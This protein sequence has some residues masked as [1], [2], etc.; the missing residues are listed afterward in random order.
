[1]KKISLIFTKKRG[2]NKAN[3]GEICEKAIAYWES[4]SHKEKLQ[5]AKEN[6]KGYFRFDG[7]LWAR[8]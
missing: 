4:L 2:L 1:M 8:F 3:T 5:Q 7:D 6:G